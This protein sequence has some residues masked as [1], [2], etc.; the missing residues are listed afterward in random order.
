MK[1][2]PGLRWLACLFCILIFGFP[3][4]RSLASDYFGSSA[5][6]NLEIR[7]YPENSLKPDAIWKI[8]QISTEHK[9]V[10]FFRVQLMPL[11][12][13]QGIHLKFTRTNPPANW[14][15]GF[16]CKWLPL[17]D[18]N[19]LE[20]R[21]FS[22][23]F[24]QETVPRLLAGRAHP[25]AHAGSLICRL[26]DVTL[27]TGSGPVHLPRAEMRM[28]GQAGRIVWQDSGHTVQWDLFSNQTVI[29][30]IIQRKQNEK[31]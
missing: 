26:D 7:V 8:D 30:S 25:I 28:E 4:S 23:A 12:V 24:P 18:R 13:V 11:L 17:K 27:Q 29:S 31:L 5:T 19:A 15:E 21:D 3:V 9:R 10:G 2:Y 16:Q 1:I 22:I 14:L 6:S 20:W